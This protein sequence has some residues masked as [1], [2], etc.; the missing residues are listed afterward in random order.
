[1]FVCDAV[2]DSL[3]VGD[4]LVGGFK[5]ARYAVT[6]HG[7]PGRFVLMTTDNWPCS[8]PMVRVSLYFTWWRRGVV[9][10]SLV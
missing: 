9:V 1:M 5:V 7:G 4:C 2:P 8:S 6:N 3:D 10:A